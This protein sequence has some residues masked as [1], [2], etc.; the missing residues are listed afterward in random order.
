MLQNHLV[1][2][3]DNVIPFKFQMERVKNRCT[4]KIT[5]FSTEQTKQEP[6]LQEQVKYFWEYSCINI[7]TIHY[8]IIFIHSLYKRS[9]FNYLVESKTGTSLH[10][11]KEDKTTSKASTCEFW[12][13]I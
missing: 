8:K 10:Y 5:L 12:L 9:F 2:H 7:L 1:H 4:W 13:K 3:F 11:D 6:N